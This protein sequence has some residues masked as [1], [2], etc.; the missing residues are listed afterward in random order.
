MSR[1]VR[2]D[3]LV[4]EVQKLALFGGSFDP[5]HQGHI[6][7]VLDAKH[8]LGLGRVL[9]LPTASPPH[10]VGGV[11]APA[12][13][14]YAMVELALLGH[15]GLEAHPHELTLGRPAYTIETIEAFLELLP[16]A[17]LYLLIGEDSLASLGS[18][19][20]GLEIPSLVRVAVLRRPDLV[21]VDRSTLA[22][23]L[24]EAATED[25][26]IFVDNQPRSWSS[27]DIRSRLSAT[28][29]IDRQALD[30]L[31]LNY[32]NKYELYD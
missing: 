15:P 31:V 3:P 26:L 22:P 28:R 24:R 19:R 32:I 1:D 27:S 11:E 14:R 23:E 4:S 6:Q 29:A 5:I 30:P 16:A 17:E 18:W 10:K 25:R 13:S 8:Q 12:W 21:T 20:R 9:F 2:R 7:P